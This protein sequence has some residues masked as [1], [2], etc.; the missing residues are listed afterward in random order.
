MKYVY[1]VTSVEMGWDCV[2]GVYENLD[3]AYQSCFHDNPLNLSLE[4][5][6][7]MVEDGDTNYV[8]HTKKLK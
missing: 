3:D 5:M 6:E 4:Q 1:V 8:V 2:C 7:E